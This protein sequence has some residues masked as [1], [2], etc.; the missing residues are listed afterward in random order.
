MWGAAAGQ[1]QRRLVRMRCRWS[2]ADYA[3]VQVHEWPSL[4]A[5]TQHVAFEQEMEWP[6]YFDQEHI[7]GVKIPLGAAVV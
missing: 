2:R 4:E 7:L 1:R 6:R 3:M 5:L